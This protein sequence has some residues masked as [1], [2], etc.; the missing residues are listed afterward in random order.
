MQTLFLSISL[1]KPAKWEG[2]LLRFISKQSFKGAL[3]TDLPIGFSSAAFFSYNY[4]L[5]VITP[6]WDSARKTYSQVPFTCWVNFRQI[7]VCA[8]A[9]PSNNRDNDTRSLL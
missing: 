4:G 2:G 7:L 1:G 5:M 3:K 6:Y 9:P 8:S